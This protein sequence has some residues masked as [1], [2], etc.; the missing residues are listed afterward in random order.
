VGETLHLSLLPFK[1]GNFN[2]GCFRAAENLRHADV[3]ICDQ[4]LERDR[5]L[6]VAQLIEQVELRVFAVAVDTF[7]NEVANS[8]AL[9]DRDMLR[10]VVAGD[11]P[12]DCHHEI[13]VGDLLGDR[14]DLIGVDIHGRPPFVAAS[15]RSQLPPVLYL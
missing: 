3:A 2:P 10:V 14:H 11:I 5:T 8:V 15:K 12:A 1:V 13:A 7:H 4:L 6:D 9:A